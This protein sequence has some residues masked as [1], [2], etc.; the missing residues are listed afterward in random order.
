MLTKPCLS[1]QNGA[2]Y[3][4]WLA[5]ASSKTANSLFTV[6]LAKK[7]QPEGITAFALQ[8]GMPDTNLASHLPQEGPASFKEAHRINTERFGGVEQDFSGDQK[9]VPQACSTL[10]AAAFDPNLKGK[11]PNH[12]HSIAFLEG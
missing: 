3:H 1:T 9:T 11:S 4:P 7:L 6:E 8:P 10:L 2:K 12:V 5:Y